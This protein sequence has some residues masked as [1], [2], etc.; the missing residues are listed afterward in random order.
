MLQPSEV[1]HK[2]PV[3]VERGRF[4]PVTYVN[5]DLARS[6]LRSIVGLFTSV[7]RD[8]SKGKGE[9]ELTEK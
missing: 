2:R 3:L 5:L 9:A 1:L 4:R 7:S 8:A 6:A